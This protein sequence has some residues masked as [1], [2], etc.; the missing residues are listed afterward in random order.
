MGNFIVDNRVPNHPGLAAHINSLH[1]IKAHKKTVN[2]AF[3]TSLNMM[4]FT[5]SAFSLALLL[6]STAVAPATAWSYWPPSPPTPPRY[7]TP[8]PQPALRATPVPT[9]LAPTPAPTN[10]P[11]S[12]PTPVA[13]AADSV[14]EEEE[15]DVVCG[16]SDT[17]QL[18]DNVFLRQGIDTA[19]NTLTAE[20]FLAEEA[21]IGMAFSPS[22]L[23]VE[24]QAVIGLPDSNNSNNNV[25]V[26]Y[27]NLGARSPA[28]VT[29][30]DDQSKVSNASIEQEP[31]LTTMTFTLNL[32]DE[33]GIPIVES[34]DTA[35]IIYAYGSSNTLGFHAFRSSTE[36]TFTECIVAA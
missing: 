2:L 26:G 27:Y 28:G 3:P 17:I 34:G 29:L 4:K 36:V 6:G 16:L 5:S 1:K 9:T 32:L 18:E 10:A 31:G 22:G 13:A 23:M 11:T 7:P 30:L 25:P 19:T 24:N 14:E 15:E 8:A 33:N 35:R 20:L 21:W 12:A